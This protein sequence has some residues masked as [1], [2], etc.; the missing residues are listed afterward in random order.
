MSLKN[1]ESKYQVVFR[2]HLHNAETA[3]EHQVNGQILGIAD[4]KEKPSAVPKPN[5]E[6]NLKAIVNFIQAFAEQNQDQ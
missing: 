3:K 6:I 4:R 5:A 2:W 1:V